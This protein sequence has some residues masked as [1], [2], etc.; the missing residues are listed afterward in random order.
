MIN[1]EIVISFMNNDLNASVVSRAS[2]QKK[3]NGASI[4]IR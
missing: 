2:V 1:A 3:G 4:K